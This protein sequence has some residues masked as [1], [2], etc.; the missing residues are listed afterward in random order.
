MRMFA[1]AIAALAIHSPAIAATCGNWVPQTNGTSWRIC[2]DAMT[3]ERFCELK[4][5][6]LIKRIACP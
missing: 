3:G 6:D 2:A 4:R 1:F 5:G